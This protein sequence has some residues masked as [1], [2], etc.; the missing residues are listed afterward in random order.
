[1]S[2]EETL[3]LAALLHDIGQFWQRTLPERENK[4]DA[5]PRYSQQFIMAHFGQSWSESANLSLMH[6][7]PVNYLGKLIQ[8]ADVLSSREEES[9]LAEH[10][11]Y[12]Q[13][14]SVFSKM[15]NGTPPYYLPLRPLEV[16]KGI[17]FPRQEADPRPEESYVRL[18]NGFVQEVSAVRGLHR[19]DFG[20][21]IN[22]LH[23]ILYKYTWSV[24]SA[25]Y[26]SASLF[27]HL[28]MTCAIALALYKSGISESDVDLLLKDDKTLRT[29][30]PILSIICGDLCG[31]EAFVYNMTSAAE[32]SVLRGRSFYLGLLIETATHWL[33]QQLG[34][35]TTNL[36]YVGGGRFYLLAPH[37]NIESLHS[38]SRH[39]SQA[40]LKHHYGELNLAMACKDLHA[41]DFDH[42]PAFISSLESRLADVKQRPFEELPLNELYQSLFR[43]QGIVEPTPICTVCGAEGARHKLTAVG[44]ME[45][46]L[47]HSFRSLEK[48]LAAASY[49]LI[50]PRDRGLPDTQL[51]AW[52]SLFC[53]DL[54]YIV[55]LIDEPQ[56]ADLIRIGHGATLLRLNST[57]FL[58]PPVLNAA[59]YVKSSPALG[60]RF[61]PWASPHVDSS[62]PPAVIFNDMAQQSE[63]APLLGI[64]RM[65]MDDTK[66]LLRSGLNGG[67]SISELC[68]MTSTLLLFFKAWLCALCA[69]W[70]TRVEKHGRRVSI[71]YAGGDDLFVISGWS[72]TPEL[73][74]TIQRDFTEF[75]CYNPA[76]HICAG[77]AV[78]SSYSPICQLAETAGL[79][80]YGRAKMLPGKNAFDFLSHTFEWTN[81][82]K[83]AEWHNILHN[84]VANSEGIGSGK[85]PL[86]LLHLIMRLYFDY[87]ENQK[88]QTERRLFHGPTVYYGPWMWRAAYHLSRMMETSEGQTRTEL[89]RIREAL[90]HPEQLSS[91]LPKLALA[92][93]WV[94]LLTRRNPVQMP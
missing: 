47:C 27:D 42:I 40:L 50:A 38:L 73:A 87:L 21:F 30:Q 43:P 29:Q 85:A 65:D 90:I 62:L 31:I 78:D 35:Y 93:R 79:S 37:M 41:S 48:Q 56:Q 81:F 58:L 83:V 44:K 94:E 57:D 52:Q 12:W 84:T 92:A 34:L 16:K 49:M 3:V 36:I 33:L 23:H 51:D 75:T 13:L 68:T 60:F 24:P 39:L 6:H 46:D 82:H 22:T 5:H 74:S 59:K 66:W 70:D 86:D 15:G 88:Q 11:E 19:A 32:A 91:E 71:I 18:W 61:L 20:A 2:Q 54:G 28:R 1:M 4:E 10:R 80:L 9:H 64:L 45:C 14:V 89:A 63:G 53:F 55:K 77:T 72:D 26:G 7:Q 69:E 25:G 8:L 76:V 67:T 17:L